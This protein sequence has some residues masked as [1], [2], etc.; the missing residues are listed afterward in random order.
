MPKAH[1]KPMGFLGWFFVAALGAAVAYLVF[2]EPKVSAFVAALLIAGYLATLPSIRREERQLREL[3]ASR[4][5]QSICDFAREFDL[6]TVDSWVVRAVY[7]QVQKQLVHVH[8]AFPLRADDRLKEDLRLDGDDLDLDVAI[9]VEERTGRSLDN[10]KSNPYF[11]QV[12]TVR[13]LVLF[14]QA[15]ARTGAA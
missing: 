11:G 13:D 6:R 15:Q 4:E 14:F 10:A 3:A 9:E 7:E 5:G 8:P 1:A 12:R 2:T